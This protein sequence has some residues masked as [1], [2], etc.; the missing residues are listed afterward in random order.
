[1]NQR[2]W[3]WWREN[4]AGPCA[5]TILAWLTWVENTG[6]S[7]AALKWRYAFYSDRSVIFRFWAKC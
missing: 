1:M 5:R 6:G 2:L 4:T 7:R 3:N